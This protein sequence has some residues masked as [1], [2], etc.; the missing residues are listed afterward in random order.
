MTYYICLFVGFCIGYFT[1]ALM[2]ISRDGGGG[3]EE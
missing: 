1:A 3:E 2:F